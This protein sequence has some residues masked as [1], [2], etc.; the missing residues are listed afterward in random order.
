MLPQRTEPARR[1]AEAIIAK[2]A[3]ILGYRF[4]QSQNI[5]HCRAEWLEIISVFSK[6]QIYV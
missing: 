3:K 6:R 1:S 2:L 5:T 4:D